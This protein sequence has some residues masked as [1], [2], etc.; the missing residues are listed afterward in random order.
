MNTFS[1]LH[2][3]G[4]SPNFS[5]LQCSLPF[6]PNIP[7]QSTF[8]FLWNGLDFDSLTIHPL[9]PTPP[10]PI[11]S[12]FPEYWALLL[13]Q[14]W[15]GAQGITKLNKTRSLAFNILTLKLYIL[16]RSIC[17]SSIRLT[18]ACFFCSHCS[19]FFFHCFIQQYSMTAYCVRYF[20]TGC[21]YYNRAQSLLPWNLCSCEMNKTLSKQNICRKGYEVKRSRVRK[22]E[23]NSVWVI[24]LLF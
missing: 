17:V 18:Y 19:P 15:F 8:Y 4:Y 3:I 11:H 21:W 5:A 23:H 6:G 7:C 24:V 10:H 13:C 22:I 2:T 16:E 20:F 9:T 1:A 14:A 12:F